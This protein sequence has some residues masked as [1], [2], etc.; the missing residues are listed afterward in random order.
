MNILDAGSGSCNWN[1]GGLPVTGIDF[2]EKLLRD[3]LE[4]GRLLRYFRG[5][6]TRTKIA[7]GAFDIVVATEVLEHIPD[8][9][10]ALAEIHR[11]LSPRGSMVVSVPDE[12]PFSLWKTLFIPWAWYR[13]Y[14]LNQRYY[15]KQ[16]GHVQHFSPGSV[17][18]LL[19]RHGFDVEVVFSVSSLNIF[20][21][22]Y[23]DAAAAFPRQKYTD[24]TVIIP[25]LNEVYSITRIIK[26]LL[27]RYHGVRIIIVDD[28]STDGTLY[29]VEK[30]QGHSPG[31]TLIKRGPHK[32]KGI[33]ASVLEAIDKVQTPYFVVMDGD[34]Q[35]GPQ[36]VMWL[37][38]QLFGGTHL[39]VATR[40][41]VHG[42]YW[43]RKLLSW[44]GNKLAGIALR[45][46]PGAPSDALSG[47]F[48]ARTQ[49]WR[50]VTRGKEKAF[51][52]RGYKVLFDFLKLC[53]RSMIIDEV[54]FAFDARVYGTS[55]ATLRVYWEFLR[56]IW[57]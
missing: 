23:K 3:G 33:T 35:H 17:K 47:F 24:L 20:L 42:W 4:Q 31:I 2:N 50:S 29:A 49:V 18:N 19:V 15:R 46:L 37:Y 44:L 22:A 34:G 28:G 6:I 11:I 8:V 48:G 55:K 12:S 51:A 32:P 52:P 45:R 25:V 53:D 57:R 56:S 5:D 26:E 9:Q 21:I 16:C 39:S 36:Y 14:L 43:H 7:D 10:A 13:G 1:T 38:R 41:T 27:N 54:Y 40:A 30:L